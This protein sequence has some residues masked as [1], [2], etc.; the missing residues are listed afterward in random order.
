MSGQV[1][2]F[3]NAHP[4]LATCYKE[5]SSYD[6]L[7][8][9]FDADKYQTR[10]NQSI[11]PGSFCDDEH[12]GAILAQAR[13]N[14]K[15]SL[16]WEM[17]LALEKHCALLYICGHCG[18]AGHLMPGSVI[19]DVPGHTM[20][21]LCCPAEGVHM[22]PYETSEEESSEVKTEL[23]ANVEADAQANAQADAQAGAQADT[24]AGG[25]DTESK[26][27]TRILSRCP[28]NGCEVRSKGLC[29]LHCAA[30]LNQ[31]VTAL[32]TRAKQQPPLSGSQVDVIKKVRKFYNDLKRTKKGNIRA[33]VAKQPILE[34]TA[35]LLQL[36][37]D[38]P[39]VA[40]ASM[41]EDD[42]QLPAQSPAAQGD[43]S[44]VAAASV[45]EDDTQ[46]PAQSP[47][48][49]GV[50]MTA[51][52]VQEADNMAAALMQRGRE[53]RIIREQQ[54]NAAQ[55]GTAQAGQPRSTGR[56]TLGTRKNAPPRNAAVGSKKRRG[57]K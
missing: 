38:V 40:A 57:H 34:E 1:E 50:G 29:P 42:S 2:A 22:N 31:V 27:E 37:G 21:G 52:A 53:Q 10:L 56:F 32:E 3:K 26:H 4:S 54:N 24:Q 41:T 19:P 48:I 18:K 6:A 25:E 33:N 20:N 47:M 46:S 16:R 23:E 14:V 45:T 15:E 49:P 17:G 36:F 8:R 35:V 43:V 55:G 13:Q 28:D 7:P 44:V 12:A 9:G 39:V 51:A 5:P 11:G 30:Q